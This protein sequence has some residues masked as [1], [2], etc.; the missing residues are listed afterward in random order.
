MV[1]L[2]ENKMQILDHEEDFMIAGISPTDPS[3]SKVTHVS[4]RDLSSF[5]D[6]SVTK[7]LD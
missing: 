7:F 2:H 6:V 3:V 4:G 1:M 5:E